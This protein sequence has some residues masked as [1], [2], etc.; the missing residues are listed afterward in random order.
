MATIN[1]IVNLDSRKGDISAGGG[2][3]GALQIDTKPLQTLGL[4]TNFY[5]KTV[6]E[7]TVKDR[8]TKLQEVAKVAAIDANNLFGKDKDY[9]VK[10]LNNLKEF[11]AGYA[12]NPNLTIEDQLKWQTALSD[13][14]NDYLSG[15]QRALSYQT[16]LNELNTSHSGKEKEILLGELNDK[17]NNTDIA[18][19]ISSGTGFKPVAINLPGAA[20]MTFDTLLNGRNEV[21]KVNSTIYNPLAN[22][23]LASTVALGIN[24][25]NESV[26]GVEGEL[27][28]TAQG[29]AQLWAGMT[30]TFNSVLTSKDT[31]GSYK[32]FDAEGI[33]LPEKFKADNAGN[34][35][36][37]QPFNAL[38]NLDAYS[39]EKK[40]EVSQGIYSDRGITYKAPTNLDAQ[41]FGAG[42]ISFTPNGVSKEQLIQ[43]GLYQSYLGD[44][45]TKEFKETG[46]GIAQQNAD[47]T[48]KNAQTNVGQLQLGWKKFDLDKDKWKASQTGAEDMKSGALNRAQRIYNDLTK[49]ADKNGVISPDKVRQLNTEQ[50]NYLGSNQVSESDAGV[51]S[52]VF[53]PLDFG[54]DEGKR[55]E[56]AIQ[57]K[58]GEI[59]V[60]RPK[61]GQSELE[62]TQSGGFRGRWDNNRST[63]I[64]NMATNILNEQ[65][66]NAGSKELNAYA[67]IDYAGQVS[68]TE[69]TPTKGGNTYTETK[70]IN[71]VKWGMKADGTIE[72]IK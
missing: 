41:A 55:T 31:D 59:N 10:K 35:T 40:Q 36:I 71:G 58:N 4:Y 61:E 33:F 70:V 34:A 17:F 42:I 44:K 6:Y 18:T 60:L 12:K 15:K 32:Y 22:S 3:A 29:Q 38:V 13:V 47:A 50:L 37:M 7:Q 21:V 27:Q 56:A 9:L 62:R 1:D 68:P 23:Q 25:L 19:Q 14:N 65:L 28:K 39:K 20:T 30:D 24:S 46:L 67:P 16:Q 52:N 8:D 5:N 2:D 26:S 57:L 69:T 63:N 11:A 66:K 43:G 54:N 48:T 49:L 72:K 45:T 51:K 53:V 64:T